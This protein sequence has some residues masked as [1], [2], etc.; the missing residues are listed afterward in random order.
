MPDRSSAIELSTVSP[1][2]DGVDTAAETMTA[3]ETTTTSTSRHRILDRI[4]RMVDKISMPVLVS[5]ITATGATAL[6]LALAARGGSGHDT[7]A[8]S[9]EDC[10][11]SGNPDFE[12]AGLEH[13]GPQ[14]GTVGAPYVL[15][16]R[17]AGE[18]EDGR[19]VESTVVIETSGQKPA[20]E[21]GGV[22]EGRKRERVWTA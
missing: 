13:A 5:L 11:K 21:R 8:Q 4:E 2:Q 20:H 15:R 10:L 14:D 12:C 3:L 6:I 19:E 9:Y 22:K 1:R 7:G 16:F 18:D 17:E